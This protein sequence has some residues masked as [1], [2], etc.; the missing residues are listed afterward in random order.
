MPGSRSRVP[1][2]FVINGRLGITAAIGGPAEKL[3]G[4]DLYTAIS[5]LARPDFPSASFNISKVSSEFELPT[6]WGLVELRQRSP[7]EFSEP[8]AIPPVWLDHRTWWTINEVESTLLKLQSQQQPL[9]QVRAADAPGSSCLGPAV[10]LSSPEPAASSIGSNIPVYSPAIPLT[11]DRVIGDIVDPIASTSAEELRPNCAGPSSL[12]SLQT[13]AKSV[14]AKKSSLLKKT[15]STT[16]EVTICASCKCCDSDHQNKVKWIGCDNCGRWHAESCLKIRNELPLNSNFYKCSVCMTNQLI[17]EKVI[18]EWDSLNDKVNSLVASSNKPH[19]DSDKITALKKDISNE[20]KK[21]KSLEESSSKLLKEADGKNIVLKNE[22]LRLKSTI[23]SLK[24]NVSEQRDFIESI[25]FDRSEHTT[26][27]QES[28]GDLFDSTQSYT[29]PKLDID[30]S[31]QD[32]SDVLKS[33]SPLSPLNRPLSYITSPMERANLPTSMDYSASCRRAFLGSN[34]SSACTQ[35]FSEGRSDISA[36]VDLTESVS[37]D[38]DRSE[39]LTLTPTVNNSPQ[40]DL[41]S[42]ATPLQIAFPTVKAGEPKSQPKIVKISRANS[43]LPTPSCDPGSKITVMRETCT[44]P[45][46]QPPLPDMVDH[47]YNNVKRSPNAAALDVS[48]IDS[49]KKHR[50]LT[51]SPVPCSHLFAGSSLM[52]GIAEFKDLNA[53]AFSLGWEVQINRGGTTKAIL[54][55]A[56]PSPPRINHFNSAIIG[57]GSNDLSNMAR[58][59]KPSFTWDDEIFKRISSPLLSA[60]SEGLQNIPKVL[61]VLPPPRRDVPCELSQRCSSAVRHHTCH[62]N[63]IFLDLLPL[64]QSYPDFIR[65]LQRDG[66]HFTKYTLCSMITRSFNELNIPLHLEVND[67]LLQPSLLFP[68]QCLK[69]GLSTHPTMNCPS[70]LSQACKICNKLGHVDFVCVAKYRLCLQCGG[71][72]NCK[73]NHKKES[74]IK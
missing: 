26:F 14:K 8:L 50:A 11:P 3:K 39:L 30:K 71:R 21:Y 13:H 58:Q 23:N 10:L 31:M 67:N 25:N 4:G 54:D 7:Q 74:S 55:R 53:S 32:V 33:N 6:K 9:S 15:T 57:I 47:K 27:S 60:W 38:S 45:V 44:S 65:N 73:Y 66:I 48:S 35:T 56:F 52:K 20:H 62:L 59:K 12:L 37:L 22:I 40:F 69:C 61:I 18:L 29:L 17:F 28:L 1:G 43:T 68:G 51:D 34:S 24:V 36:S 2:Y 70:S 63:L 64:N 46:P 16:P 49:A 72:G 5:I 41:L 42:S 19:S